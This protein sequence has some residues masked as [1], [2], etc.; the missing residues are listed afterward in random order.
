KRLS[1]REGVTLYMTLLAMYAI[2]LHH[3][4]GKTDIVIGSPVATYR[5]RSEL[6]AVIG[7]FLNTLAL[8]VDLSGEP[9]FRELLGRVRRVAL[10]AY[11]NQEV[12]FDQVVDAV[13]PRR[14]VS[15]SPIFEVWYNHSN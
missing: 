1:Q 7:P 8:R 4:S 9:T 14:D 12:P 5:D 11:A 10:E 15:R 3:L 13:Q 6:Q 2:V